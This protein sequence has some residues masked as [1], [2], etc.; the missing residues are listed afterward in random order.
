[1][2]RDIII[3]NLKRNYCNALHHNVK[4]ELIEFLLI[5]LCRKLNVKEQ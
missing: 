4:L 1:M 5:L 3:L 2:T